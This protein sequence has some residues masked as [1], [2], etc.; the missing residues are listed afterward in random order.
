MLKNF[1]RRL[2]APAPVAPA[3]PDREVA[4][5]ALMVRIA[6]ADGSYDDE[7]R[8]RIERVLA[9]RDGL[10]PSEAEALAPARRS[11]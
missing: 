8:V 3:V 5:A 7:E 2:L 10:G 11:D 6:R 9:L 4:L 1:I